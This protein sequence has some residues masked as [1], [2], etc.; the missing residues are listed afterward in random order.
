MQTFHCLQSY[1]I[2]LLLGISPTIARIRVHDS[3]YDR[4]ILSAV[5]LFLRVM[6][7]SFKI[8]LPIDAHLHNLNVDAYLYKG[9]VHIKKSI[10]YDMH[11][12]YEK[13][14]LTLDS[15]SA[16]IIIRAVCYTVFHNLLGLKNESG[17]R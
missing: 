9:Q 1:L 4:L 15:S 13:F 16:D 2:N 3:Q 7:S 12:L 17:L 8:N 14:I 10:D 11:I 6:S 5:V